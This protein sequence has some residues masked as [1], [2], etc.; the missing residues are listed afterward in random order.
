MTSKVVS[1]RKILTREKPRSWKASVAENSSSVL[2]SWW[3][4]VTL[5]WKCME[6]LSLWGLILCCWSLIAVDVGISGLYIF[7]H[8]RRHS[9]L[10]TYC[11]QTRHHVIASFSVH[12]YQKTWG[13]IWWHRQNCLTQN[14]K[15]PTTMVLNSFIENTCFSP[16]NERIC[17]RYQEYWN[18]TLKSNYLEHYFTI[19]IRWES[20]LIIKKYFWIL[21][22][23][24]MLFIHLSTSSSEWNLLEFR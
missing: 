9:G 5:S 17:I 7:E 22:V 23:T 8:A 24:L 3:C 14:L 16:P 15:S 11:P 12:L 18:Q 21:Y 2:L 19:I 10:T 13:C 4:F 20:W 1:R 6:R